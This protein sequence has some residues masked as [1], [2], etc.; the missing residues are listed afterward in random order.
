MP[1]PTRPAAVAARAAGDGSPAA[2]AARPVLGEA[3]AADVAGGWTVAPGR[4]VTAPGARKWARADA[5][6][7]VI[8]VV[9]LPGRVPLTPGLVAVLPGVAPELPGGVPVPPGTLPVPPG[10][11]PVPPDAVAAT[12]GGVT[13]PWAVPSIWL[14][15][16]VADVVIPLTVLVAVVTIAWVVPSSGVTTEV[17]GAVMLLT[18][19]SADAMVSLPVVTT[20]VAVEVT[21]W[22]AGAVTAETVPLTEDVTAFPTVATRV[23]VEEAGP[24]AAATVPV[25][26]DV[27]A[28]PVEA[29]WLLA[30]DT[31]LLAEDTAPLAEEAESEALVVAVGVEAG[32]LDADPESVTVETAVWAVEVVCPVAEDRPPATEEVL[33]ATPPAG[34]SWAV[35]ALGL[36]A[37]DADRAVRREKATAAPMAAMATPAAHRQSRRTLVTSPLVTT[38][39]L[40]RSG[41]FV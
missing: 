31:A 23:T 11:E 1:R 20:R 26:E 18:A 25:S 3:A 30:E 15:T 41:R 29:A 39:N 35:V 19:P 8:A 38:S 6:G 2:I 28:L 9:V 5:A 16:E 4:E 37:A 7:V 27:T 34:P 14:T 32:V 36:V 33:L 40:I 13:T 21:V 12:P 22:V 17:T 24:V 10:E